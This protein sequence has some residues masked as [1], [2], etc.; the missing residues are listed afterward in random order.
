MVTAEAS[1]LPPLA[2]IEWH[3]QLCAIHRTPIANDD[4]CEWVMAQANAH[5]AS[6]A[7]GWSMEGHHD[8][9]P[10]TDIVVYD[11]APLLEWLRLKLHARITPAL[12]AQV[13]EAST[14]CI[15]LQTMQSCSA[16]PLISLCSSSLCAQFGLREEEVWLEDAFIIKCN[17]R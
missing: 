12:C 6:L 13:R 11:S 3:E 10:T 17:R 16:S 8:A 2:P 7:G 14:A 4:E 1:A 9:H 5:A 15:D